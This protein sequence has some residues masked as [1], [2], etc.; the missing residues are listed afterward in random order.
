MEREQGRKRKRGGREGERGRE[1]L[2]RLQR[3]AELVELLPSLVESR[4]G[5]RKGKREGE[6]AIGGLRRDGEVSRRSE[7][8]HCPPFNQNRRFNLYFILFLL[9]LDEVSNTITDFNQKSKEKKSMKHGPK[10][11][12]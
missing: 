11:L 9:L 6:E 3:A 7:K 5:Q 1:G 8:G 12:F 4:G 10:P 2:Q